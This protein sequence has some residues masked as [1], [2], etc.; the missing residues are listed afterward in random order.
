MSKVS[1]KSQDTVLLGGGAVLSLS[2]VEQI[3]ERSQTRAIADCLK[4]LLSR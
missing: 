4:F 2:A 1:A 3:A